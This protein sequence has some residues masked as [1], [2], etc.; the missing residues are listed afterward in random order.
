MRNKTAEQWLEKARKDG[1]DWV[2]KAIEN[3]AKQPNYRDRKK[4][5]PLQSVAI[6]SEF[7]WRDSPQG[8]NYWIKIYDGIFE[9]EKSKKRTP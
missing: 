4:N 9:S 3:I 5:Y 6:W 7:D 1:A 2:D 8:H